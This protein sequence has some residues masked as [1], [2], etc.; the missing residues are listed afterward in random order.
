MSSHVRKKVKHL[1]ELQ[2][3]QSTRVKKKNNNNI[4]LAT[5]KSG[6]Q[7]VL[8][9]FPQRFDQAWL[10]KMLPL[11]QKGTMFQGLLFSLPYAFCS[12]LGCC[13]ENYDL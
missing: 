6:N 4:P 7:F 9:A 1:S 13:K 2:W 11:F 10:S 12:N 3:Q 5:M 8:D